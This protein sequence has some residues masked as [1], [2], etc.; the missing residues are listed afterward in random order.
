MEG[1]A[2]LVRPT[3]SVSIFVDTTFLTGDHAEIAILIGGA[4]PTVPALAGVD[5][6]ASLRVASVDSTR[7]VIVA[8]Q[9]TIDR[10]VDGRCRL[11]RHDV[12][13]DHEGFKALLLIST[14]HWSEWRLINDTTRQSHDRENQTL[15]RNTHDRH[16]QR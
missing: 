3:S 5:A 16:P 1:L 9:R 6:L 8:G 10:G 13:R 15:Q 2:S 14:R 7:L 4:G 12:F 11:W